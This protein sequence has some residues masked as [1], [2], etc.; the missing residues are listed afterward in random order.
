MG[1]LFFDSHFRKAVKVDQRVDITVIIN[2]GKA[3]AEKLQ[4]LRPLPFR[5]E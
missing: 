4:K 1:R 5:L 2:A 3:E